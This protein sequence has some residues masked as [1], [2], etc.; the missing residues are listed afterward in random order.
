[1]EKILSDKAEDLTG[2]SN[3]QI[4]I[5]VPVYNAEKYVGKC[6]RSIQAQTYSNWKLFLVDDGSTDRSG[7]FCDE[8]AKKDDRIKVLHKENCGSYMARLHG[9]KHIDDGGYCFFCDSDDTLPPNAL[10]LLYTEAICSG[11]DLI[12]GNVQRVYKSV[13]MKPFSYTAV[14]IY[15]KE[16]ILEKLYL[17]CFGGGGYAVNLWGKLFKTSVLKPIMLTIEQHPR[18]FADDLNVMIH[19]M[20]HLN[21]LSVI[22][23]VVYY[24][25][26]GGGTSRFMPSFLDDNILMYRVKMRMAQYCTSKLNVK[27]LVGVELKNIIV[28]YWIICEKNQRYPHG[29]L[30]EEVKVVCAQPEV[31]EALTMLQW[32]QSGLPG[33]NQPLIERDY[34]AICELIKQK[35]RKDRPKNVLKKILVG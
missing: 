7:H 3:S 30:L 18:F 4:S 20:P 33:I 1:M 29:S 10:Q 22:N 6:I 27:K 28:T 9:V 12:S 15:E 31:Q 35:V 8:F 16:E 26:I 24:Y 21:R 5:V 34:P 17:C 11:A 32:D 25:W 23:K 14:G 13:R 19:L 2:V